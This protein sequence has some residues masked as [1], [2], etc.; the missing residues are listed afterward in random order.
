MFV[1]AG[2]LGIIAWVASV[3]WLV[4]GILVLTDKDGRRFAEKMA[5][6]QVIEVGD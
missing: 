1:F 4:E 5:N 2:L 3:L 6:T